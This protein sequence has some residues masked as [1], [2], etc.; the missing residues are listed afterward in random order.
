MGLEKEYSLDLEEKLSMKAL[1]ICD[2]KLCPLT[3][4]K[5]L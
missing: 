3:F 1:D 4:F 2:N 5:F